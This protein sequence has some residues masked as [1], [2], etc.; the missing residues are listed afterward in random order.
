LK[1]LFYNAI[2]AHILYLMIIVVDHYSVFSPMQNPTQLKNTW[3][4]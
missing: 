4:N 3:G 2:P 1:I